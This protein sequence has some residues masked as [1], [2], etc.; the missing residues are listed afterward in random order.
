MFKDK[1]DAKIKMTRL[2]NLGVYLTTKEV[3]EMESFMGIFDEHSRKEGLAEGEK[4]LGSLINAMIE[5]GESNLIQRI[6]KDNNLK[7]TYYKKYHI[8]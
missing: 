6:L 5:H 2:E 3:K 4:R 8:V 1:S 7:E